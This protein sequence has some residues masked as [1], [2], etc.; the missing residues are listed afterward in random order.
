MLT[1]EERNAIVAEHRTHDGDSG[2]P[3]V[4]IALLTHDIKK[5]TEHM[6]VHRKDFHSRRGL[7]LK[8][9]RRSKLLR[10]LNRVEHD[11]YIAITDKLGLRR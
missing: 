4:Q 5:L 11:R 9:S 3:E 10:Y 6:K 2:S 8:V 1:K 7:L